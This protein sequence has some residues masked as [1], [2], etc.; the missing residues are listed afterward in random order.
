MRKSNHANLQKGSP[1]GGIFM[2]KFS[3]GCRAGAK[4]RDRAVPHPA[5]PVGGRPVCHDQDRR[6]FS[7]VDVDAQGN[8]VVPAPGKNKFRG[9]NEI[10][11]AF[12]VV[13]LV[14]SHRGGDGN[15]RSWR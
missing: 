10:F 9:K 3:D 5:L 8:P 11:A 6:F 14:R 1:R 4:V 7:Y 12:V 13:D 15:P 2:N